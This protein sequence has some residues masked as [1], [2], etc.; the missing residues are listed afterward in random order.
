MNE[1]FMNA[2]NLI[3]QNV[4]PIWFMRQAGR[5]QKSYR[6]LREK[7]SFTTICKTAELAALTAIAPIKEFDFDTAILFSDILFPLE[8]LGLDY[9]ESAPVLQHHIRSFVDLKLLSEPDLNFQLDALKETRRLLP[10]NKSLIGFV[11]GPFTLFCFASCDAPHKNI[12]KKEIDLPLFSEFSK[13]ITPILKKQIKSQL[14]SGAEFVVIFDSFAALLPSNFDYLS[15][16]NDLTC[17]NMD[18][19]LYFSKEATPFYQTPSTGLA[20][21]HQENLIDYLKKTHKVI[22]GNFDERLLLLPKH[23]L[24]NALLSY[25]EKIKELPLENRAG[26]IMSL[27]H[28]VPK[29]T[30]EENVKFTV[31][32]VRESFRS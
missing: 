23:E 8:T 28:G 7:Y 17:E 12:F 1:A 22:Q 18:R 25:L 11:G 27:G 13:I 31:D 30:P 21:G 15:I 26:W 29:D 6:I 10:S 24:K 20:L 16:I 3:P 32:V 14:N 9:P 4:P 5:Y 2:I 19:L